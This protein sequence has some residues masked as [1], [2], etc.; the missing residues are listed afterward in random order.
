MS[1]RNLPFQE[2]EELTEERIQARIKQIE[3]G[4]KHS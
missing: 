3:K 2:V 4:K 1:S